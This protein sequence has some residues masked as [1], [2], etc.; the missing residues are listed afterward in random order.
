MGEKWLSVQKDRFP[1]MRR[2]AEAENWPISRIRSQK[3]RRYQMRMMN[4]VWKKDFRWRNFCQ[5]EKGVS[6]NCTGLR[7]SQ[8]GSHPVDEMYPAVAVVR[9]RRVWVCGVTLVIRTGIPDSDS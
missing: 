8:Q 6:E 4:M 9:R 2:S 5:M 3:Q 7:E 1:G